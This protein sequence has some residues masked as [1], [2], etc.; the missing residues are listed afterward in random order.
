[1]T[2]AENTAFSAC[3]KLPFTEKQ[4]LIQPSFIGIQISSEKMIKLPGLT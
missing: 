4:M 1:M 2:N 3:V